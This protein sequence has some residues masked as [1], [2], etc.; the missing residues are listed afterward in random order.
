LEYQYQ[1]LYFYF[2]FIV[3]Y[4][5]LK[6]TL[7]GRNIYAVGSNAKAA[8][9]AGVNVKRTIFFA[10][11]ISGITGGATA[12]L[13]TSRIFSVVGSLGSG[14][15]L[16]IISAVVIGGISLMGGEGTILGSL[17]GALIIEMVGNIL[18]LARISPFFTLVAKGIV[19]WLAV[20]I[21][22]ARKGYVFRKPG[23]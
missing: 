23:E 7:I 3:G 19:L 15:E 6:Y 17:V 21:D 18:T 11:V 12:V 8:W 1:L 5:L 20:L 9:L 16:D 4:L 2:F 13:L 14:L 22:M 10:Y